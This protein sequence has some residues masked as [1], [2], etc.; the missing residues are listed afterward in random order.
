MLPVDAL[1]CLSVSKLHGPVR[2][3]LSLPSWVE[4]SFCIHPSIGLAILF[5]TSRPSSFSFEQSEAISCALDLHDSSPAA[6]YRPLELACVSLAAVHVHYL[7]F[8]GPLAPQPLTSV[9]RV[10]PSA[11]ARR[12]T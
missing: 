11:L 7:S 9:K 2:D 1:I 4:P 12:I 8:A 3:S 6:C 10:R 5:F